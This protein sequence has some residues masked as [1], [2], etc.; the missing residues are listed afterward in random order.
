MADTP[1]A[2]RN[3][4]CSRYVMHLIAHRGVEERKISVDGGGESPQE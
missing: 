2:D 3:V 4:G 1:N